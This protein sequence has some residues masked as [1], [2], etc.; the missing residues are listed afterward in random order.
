MKQKSLSNNSELKEEEERSDWLLANPGAIG[1]RCVAGLLG[2]TYERCRGESTGLTY[3]IVAPD[4]K[5]T[6]G[7]K[8]WSRG[9]KS[10]DASVAC[11]GGVSAVMGS[12]GLDSHR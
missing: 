1:S 9:Q 4:E 3:I 8:S 11:S 12:S 6:F 10:Q 7:L 5:L 2:G